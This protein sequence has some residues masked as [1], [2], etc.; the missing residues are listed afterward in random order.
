MYDTKQVGS[1]SYIFERMTQMIEFLLF[2]G[3]CSGLH[4]LCP[5]AQRMWILSVYPV[6]NSNQE[7]YPDKVSHYPELSICERTI[8]YRYGPRE[9]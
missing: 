3:L 8:I 7:I 2:Y 9:K 6:T 1:G 5:L 4:F